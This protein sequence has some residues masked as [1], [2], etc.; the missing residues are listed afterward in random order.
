MLELKSK[1]TIQQRP[2]ATFP[3]RNKLF[4]FNFVCSIEI[5]TSWE[6]LVDSG[7][8]IFPRNLFFRD[9][10]NR[11]FSWQGL[12]VVN[13]VDPVILR[14]DKIKIELGYNYEKRKDT[15][16]DEIYTE[17]EGYISNVKSSTPLEIEFE[18][19]FWLLKQIQAPNKTFDTS[20]ELMC[21]ELLQGTGFTFKDKISGNAINT[22]FGS[23][24]TQNETVA[25][26]FERLKKDF[27]FYSSFR[28][29][30]LRCGFIVY[31]PDDRVRHKFKFQHNIIESDLNYKRKD[32]VKIGL[33]IHTHQTELAGTRKDGAQKFKSKKHSYFG[34]Y[35]KNNVLQVVEIARKPSQ[36]DGEIRTINLM[37]MPVSEIKEY[38]NKQLGRMSFEGFRG[39]VKLFGLPTVKHGD[40]IKFIDDLYPERNGEYM[41]KSVTKTF[42]TDG[43]RQDVEIDL[44]I[45]NITQSELNKGL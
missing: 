28:G 37:S 24:T 40:S 43:Y 15:Y 33:E 23:F 41:V 35:D 30:E 18:D 34:Y 25:Q 4:S 31:Y 27:N 13:G 3:N 45:D 22:T 9:K 17:F 44:K 12:S 1:I 2:T 8:L 32:D 26:V 42:G 20:L 14:G 19:N 6:N 11:V 10:N 7:S 39:S 5:K 29:N 38:I 36:F 21:K 16:E